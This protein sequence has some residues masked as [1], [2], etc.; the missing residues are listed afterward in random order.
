MLSP[1]GPGRA[2]HAL[3]PEAPAVLGAITIAGRI[4][5]IRDQG[6][7]N[8]IDLRDDTGKIQAFLGKKQIGEEIFEI[9]KLTIGISGR[10]MG[11]LLRVGRGVVVTICRGLEPI[12]KA[13]CRF[14]QVS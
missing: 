10:R 14:D 7:S 9:G 13:S 5:A 12:R 2:L 3:P 8:W 4:T 6:K 1:G 11:Q